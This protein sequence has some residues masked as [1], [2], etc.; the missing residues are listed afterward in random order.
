MVIRGLFAVEKKVM[1]VVGDGARGAQVEK[2]S[3][4]V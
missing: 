2:M 3:G 4:S 1:C